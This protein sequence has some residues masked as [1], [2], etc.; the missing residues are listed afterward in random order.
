MTG[1][2]ASDD[3]PKQMT[4]KG[5]QIPIPTRDAFLRDLGKVALPAKPDPEQDE[6]HDDR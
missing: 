6:R 4:A 5:V 2:A 1:T 3:Q